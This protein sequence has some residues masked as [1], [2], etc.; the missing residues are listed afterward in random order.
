MEL[1]T[2]VKETFVGDETEVGEETTNER[3]RPASRVESGG[4]DRPTTPYRSEAD[5]EVATGQTRKETLLEL[6]EAHE[7]RVKQAELVDLT[8]W[9]K[10]TVSRQL[11]ELERDDAIDRV[12]IG[13]CKVVL[14]PD[15]PL[16]GEH[17]VS[18]DTPR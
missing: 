14:L 15:E 12:Q 13:R 18:Y 10:S 11:G 6:V 17:T 5:F 16:V 9:S 8:E 2:T 3:E 4:E 7:G 1:L